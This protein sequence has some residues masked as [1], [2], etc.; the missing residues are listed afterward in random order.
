MGSDPKIPLFT[1]YT[2]LLHPD[3]VHMAAS[4]TGHNRNRERFSRGE[5]SMT[6]GRI[7]AKA[8]GANAVDN[9]H[10]PLSDGA[11]VVAGA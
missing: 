4:P 8:G 10:G 3:T 7:T 6:D 9:V 11:W 1:R 2:G 5:D